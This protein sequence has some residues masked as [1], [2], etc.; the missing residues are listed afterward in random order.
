MVFDSPRILRAI[1]RSFRGVFALFGWS[2]PECY[3]AEKKY[4]MVVAPHTS[5]WDFFLMVGAA[6]LIGRP[7]RFMGKHSVFIGPVGWVL[8]WLGGIAVE[9]SSKHNFVQTLADEFARCEE[10]VLII[11][12]EG[13]RS[14]VAHWKPGFY[15]IAHAAGVPVYQVSLDFTLKQVAFAAQPFTTTGNYAKDIVVIQSYYAEISASHPGK[16]SS[17]ADCPN[18]KRGCDV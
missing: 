12:P 7:I 5:N 10:M 16:D 9:R 2:F 3:P 8:R 13:T 11:A 17:M 14:K 6:A 15:H 18:V 1:G 4:V